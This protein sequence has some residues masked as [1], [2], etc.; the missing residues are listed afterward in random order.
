MIYLGD[1]VLVNLHVLVLLMVVGAEQVDVGISTVLYVISVY[2]T[3][4]L[5]FWSTA[6]N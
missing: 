2:D 3:L 5:L 6:V 1:V 4:L